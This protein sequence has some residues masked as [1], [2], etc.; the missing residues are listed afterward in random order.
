MNFAQL[1]YVS[2]PFFVANFIQDRQSS[3]RQLYRVISLMFNK[4]NHLISEQTKGVSASILSSLLFAL[5]PAYVQL[6]PDMAPSLIAGGESHWLAVQR[7]L[8][9]TLLFAILLMITRRLPLLISAL[10]ARKVWFR[11]L[12]SAI[13]VAPQYWLF[14][15][16][17][18]NGETLNLALGYFT[19][20]IVMVLIGRFVY[21]ES[22]SRLQ[23][24]ACLFALLGTVWAYVLSS[25]VSWVV[26][27]V[28]LGYPVYF[29]NRKAISLPADIGLA[30]DHIILLPF[31]VFGMFILYPSEYFLHLPATTNLYYLGLAVVSVTPMLLYLYAYTKLPVSLFG[32]LGYVEPT[33][34]FIVGLLIGS[35]I[36]SQEVPT[37]LFIICAL[38]ALVTDG[39]K[40]LKNIRINNNNRN[41][42]LL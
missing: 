19:L 20:P 30:I 23:K 29:I 6:R 27:V 7:I 26:L 39:H 34:I 2:A 32:L 13:L 38:V 42:E 37:Y 18:A 21:Q 9:S 35:T 41:N 28:A 22:L 11:Y 3:S 16:A 17:P 4:K 10:K 12:M 31:A 14:V 33:F 5:I 8:W 40:R 36:T 24:I 25:G 15:W 1:Y